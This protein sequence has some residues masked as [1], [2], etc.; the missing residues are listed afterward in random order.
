[1]TIPG[2]LQILARHKE[3]HAVVLRIPDADLLDPGAPAS[4]DHDEV[5]ILAQN[6]EWT[7]KAGGLQ[8][9]PIELDPLGMEAKLAGKFNKL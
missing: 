8:R 1:M 9:L 6:Q 5:A 4:G 7:G 2:P 3:H